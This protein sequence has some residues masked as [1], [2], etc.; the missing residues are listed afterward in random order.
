MSRHSHSVSN[1]PDDLGTRLRNS[2]NRGSA[3]DLPTEVVTGASGRTAPKL[4]NP[5]ARLQVA[6]GAVALVAAVAVAAL[7]VVPSLGGAPLFTAA[8]SSASGGVA[9]ASVPATNSLIRIWAEYRYLP[10]ATLST[11][12]GTGDVYQLRR[13]GSGAAR[14]A[15]LDAIFG[16]TGA[17]T[18]DTSD[19]SN[20]A[21]TTGA[22]DGTNPSLEVTWSG[23]GDWWYSDPAADPQPACAVSGGAIGSGGSSTNSSGA[24]PPPGS[25]TSTGPT[26]SPNCHAGT[27]ATTPS[28]APTGEDARDQA[29]KL[30]AQ[31]GFVVS[32]S[33]IQIST[34][35]T[36]TTATASLT[37][38]GVQTALDW[39]VTWSSDGTIASANGH[40]VT[41][42]DRGSFG[43]I[44]ATDAVGRLSDSRWYGS[45][46]A[47]YNSGVRAFSAIGTV[48]GSGSSSGSVARPPVATPQVATPAPTP[49]VTPTD[50]PTD[51]PTAVPTATPTTEPTAIPT[52]TGAPTAV[53]TPVPVQTGPPIIDVTIERAEP[54]LLLMNDS[55][56][57]EWLVPG[58]AMR[59]QDEWWNGVVSLVPGVIELPPV[60]SV[61]PDEIVPAKP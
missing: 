52:P 34:D 9:S 7:V 14:A 30:F 59:V 53:P 56:G 49:T 29:Q 12:G 50:A 17:A 15:A 28:K 38:A 42:V 13:D 51:S 10:G 47:K 45:T 60:P 1:L 48:T 39:G 6:G 40:S 19:P 32:T 20:P 37:V 18:A 31:T 41:V 57:D 23:A 8:A 16:L 3:P 11:S 4:S 43:T 61:T 24:V 21:W 26:T 33:D 55:T 27:G 58:Y 2:L 22:T 54:T 46:G 5:R 36:Q 44:S 25:T 35:S